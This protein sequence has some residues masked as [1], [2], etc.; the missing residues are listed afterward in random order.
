[1]S[2]GE[3]DFM[4]VIFIC[5]KGLHAGEG[6]IGIA[7][8]IVNCPKLVAGQRNVVGGAGVDDMHFGVAIGT[9]AIPHGMRE[10]ADGEPVGGA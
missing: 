9:F 8:G 7:K 10:D 5:R 4:F 6:G 3:A 2:A 1:M